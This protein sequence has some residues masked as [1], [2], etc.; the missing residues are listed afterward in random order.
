MRSKRV[1]CARS[2]SSVFRED[3]F[4]SARE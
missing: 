2:T 3:I 4:S 1:D